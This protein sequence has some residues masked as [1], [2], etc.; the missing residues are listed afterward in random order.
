LVGDVIFRQVV[1]CGG[2][3]CLAS[4]LTGLK[5]LRHTVDKCFWSM[6]ASLVQIHDHASLL[7]ILSCFI[8]DNQSWL[9]VVT[10]F[11]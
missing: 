4:Y 5:V 6:H 11:K 3:T 10:L 8:L 7:L 1:S 2:L 9:R